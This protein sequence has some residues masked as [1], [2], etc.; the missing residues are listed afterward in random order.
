MCGVGDVVKI[1]A[2]EV[3][4]V[5]HR[6]LHLPSPFLLFLNQFHRLI[7]KDGTRQVGLVFV[8]KEVVA[9]NLHLDL[10]LGLLASH[11]AN[12]CILLTNR[13]LITVDILLLLLHC[14]LDDGDCGLL[15]VFYFE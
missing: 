1:V 10:L 6:Q 14:V 12:R 13:N 5:A 3:E 4:E 11:V 9:C 2:A 8:L 7:T 15:L